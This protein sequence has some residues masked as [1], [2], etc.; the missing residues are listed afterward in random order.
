VAEERVLETEEGVRLLGLF[1]PQ[2]KDQARGLILLLHGWL[3]SAYANYIMALGEDLYAQGYAIFRLNLRDHGQTYHL[4]PEIF[5]SDRLAEVVDAAR[6][7]AALTRD[8]PFHIIGASLGGN[9]ALR[10]AWQYSQ[11]PLSNMG[12]TIAINPAINPYLTT[13]ALDRSPIYLTYF[14]RKWRKALR[15]KEI[16]FPELYDFSEECAARTCLAMTEIF[17][18]NHSPYPDA[19]AYFD[20]Y[21][22]TLAMMAALRSPVTMLTSV[23]D[24]IVPVAD[25]YQFQKV[26]PYLNL[27]IQD[28]GG[29]V[30]FIDIW[31]FRH[32]L[33]QTILSILE[34]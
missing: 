21:T 33:N 12:H 13:L 32:W 11:T 25:F 26:S 3:G 10:L 17:I 6:Q 4:N 31:P 34:S 22:V 29:H 30:G 19:R 15:Q 27:C 1:S 8:K 24:P 14:R 5:R 23:D 2:P 28:Y 18:R 20:Q 7:V 16:L 9:F